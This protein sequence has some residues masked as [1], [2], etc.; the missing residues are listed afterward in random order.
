M[1]L[2]IKERSN[3][4]K[5]L[6]Q[7]DILTFSLMMLLST[8]Q[9]TM[10]MSVTDFN[11][12]FVFKVLVFGAPLSHGLYILSLEFSNNRCFGVE[13]MDRSGAVLGNFAT[14]IP[15]AELIRY[16]EY[17]HRAFFKTKRDPN[18]PSKFEKDLFKGTGLKT[19]YLCLYPLIYAYRL[20]FR[21]TL[22]LN[23]FL[24]WNVILQTAFNMYITQYYGLV[25]MSYIILSTYVGLCPMHPVATHM[26]MEH[27]RMS[28]SVK[29][30]KIY[31]Y[32]GAINPFIF[33]AGM[34]RERHLYPKIPWSK[35]PM[36][37]RLYHQELTKNNYDSTL[38]AIHD[39]IF[40]PGISLSYS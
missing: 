30:S 6:K 25:T 14:G 39:F 9:L 31:S 12:G 21:H 19:L 35:L 38:Q 20:L 17:E 37:K 27:Q 2:S 29:K 36:I 34:H 16:F 23:R 15:Y 11:A 24:I 13:V 10:S 8:M 1:R 40:S 28:L 32:Y 33:H 3:F 4:I 5:L 22:T 26:L 18:R 7:P